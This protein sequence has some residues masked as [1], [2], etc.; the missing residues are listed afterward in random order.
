MKKERKRATIAEFSPTPFVVAGR[1]PKICRAAIARQPL[2]HVANEGCAA[3]VVWQTKWNASFD[4]L[5][6]RM[7]AHTPLGIQSPEKSRFSSSAQTLRKVL[8]KSLARLK[9]Y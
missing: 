7:V 9:E 4:L 2:L 6:L 3:Q 8:S 1:R 5:V